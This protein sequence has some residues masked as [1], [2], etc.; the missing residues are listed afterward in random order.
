[1]VMKG[2]TGGRRQDHNSF[3]FASELLRVKT[4]QRLHEKTNMQ[5]DI[6]CKSE[7]V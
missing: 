3:T 2:P 4:T 7:R 1:M 6:D 5:G